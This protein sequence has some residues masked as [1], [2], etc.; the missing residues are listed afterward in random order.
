[1]PT[2][3]LDKTYSQLGRPRLVPA[4]V[5]ERICRERNAGTS[6]GAVARGLTAEGELSP[7]GHTNWQTSIVRRIYNSATG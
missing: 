6:F 5:V 1:M 4:P 2:R 3:R 7:V